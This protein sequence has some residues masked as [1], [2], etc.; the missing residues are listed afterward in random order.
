MMHKNSVGCPHMKYL[1][2]LTESLGDKKKSFHEDE[3]LQAFCNLFVC[4]SHKYAFLKLYNFAFPFA[5]VLRR[6]SLHLLNAE[7]LT[8]P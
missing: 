1:N 2:L 3:L 8:V 5:C 6:C 4:F 7:Q